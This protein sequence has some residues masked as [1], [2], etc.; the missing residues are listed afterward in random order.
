M[1]AAAI[2][3]DRQIEADVGRIVVAE[4]AA[5]V[6]GADLGRSGA[7]GFRPCLFERAPTVVER[8]LQL[9]REAMGEIQPSEGGM[10]ANAGGISS[11]SGIVTARSPRTAVP[12]ATSPRMSRSRWA[13]G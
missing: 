11:G 8:F 1:L 4:D 13:I 6:L 3:V 7:G 10:T 9:G 5:R 12:P 2:R